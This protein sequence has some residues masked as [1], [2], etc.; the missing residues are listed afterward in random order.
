MKP[1]P[2]KLLPLKSLPIRLCLPLPSGSF[3]HSPLSPF[4]APPDSVKT[5]CGIPFSLGHG[6]IIL[7]SRG[8][9]IL[10]LRWKL[11]LRQAPPCRSC[12]P[13]KVLERPSLEWPYLTLG[14]NLLWGSLEP[15]GGWRITEDL[16]AK[17]GKQEGRGSGS[18]AWDL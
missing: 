5:S 18:P 17:Q 13:C 8:S 7:E 3:Y 14:R 12:G 15:Y 10:L 4:P 1:L 16:A 6:S 2:G 11:L 9:H